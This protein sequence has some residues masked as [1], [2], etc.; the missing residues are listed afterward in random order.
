MPVLPDLLLQMWLR[1]DLRRKRKRKAPQDLMGI[2]PAE[3]NS[4]ATTGQSPNVSKKKLPGNPLLLIAPSGP[5]QSGSSH[6]GHA[7]RLKFWQVHLNSLGKTILTNMS[8]G[9]GVSVVL[10]LEQMIGALRTKVLEQKSHHPGRPIILVGWNVGA[11]VA[12]H[13]SLVESVNAVVCLGFPFTGLHGPRGDCEDPLLGSQTPT[14]FV[15]GQNTCDCS[16]DQLQDLREHMR[17]ETGMLVVGGADEQLRLSHRQKRE[18][19]LTQA[20]ADRCIIDEVYQFLGSILSMNASLP[21]LP[22]ADVAQ[23][24]L[25]R[26]RK[27][28]APQDLMGIIP[29]ENNSFA[30]TGQSPNVSKPPVLVSGTGRGSKRGGKAARLATSFGSSTATAEGTRTTTRKRQA[31]GGMGAGPRKRIALGLSHLGMHTTRSS[32]SL[33]SSST[34]TVSAISNAPELSGLLQG[35]RISRPSEGDSVVV[36]GTRSLVGTSFPLT[37]VLTFSKLVEGGDAGNSGTLSAPATLLASAIRSGDTSDKDKAQQQQFLVKT[38]GST[39]SPLA[40]PISMAQRLMAGGSSPLVHI[41]GTASSGSSQIHQLLTSI[42]CSSSPSAPL[43]PQAALL[44]NTTA[45]SS[46]P[47]A[48]VTSQGVIRERAVPEKAETS[49]HVPREKDICETSLKE[50][51]QD[52]VVLN[53][54]SSEDSDLPQTTCVTNTCAVIAHISQKSQAAVSETSQAVTHVMQSSQAN[55]TMAATVSSSPTGQL[56]AAKQNCLTNP[57]IPGQQSSVSKATIGKALPSLSHNTS[58]TT[59][60]S[61]NSP[62]TDMILSKSENTTSAQVSPI[63]KSG[64][65]QLAVTKS[66]INTAAVTTHSVLRVAG[67]VTQSGQAGAPTAT[68]SILGG[69]SAVLISP[70]IA[71]SLSSAPTA[72]LLSKSSSGSGALSTT[73]KPAMEVLG[74]VSSVLETAGKGQQTTQSSTA[75]SSLVTVPVSL[76]KSGVLSKTGVIMKSDVISALKVSRHGTPIPSQTSACPVSVGSSSAVTPPSLTTTATAASLSVGTGAG[77]GGH[78]SVNAVSYTASSKPVLPTPTSTRTRKIKTP[79]QYDL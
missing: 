24:D 40:I 63:V 16:I 38:G 49:E 22:P 14:L 57:A 71:K 37:K 78:K 45:P 47:A 27:R 74:K 32:T 31:R 15:I 48:S 30:T 52:S 26:K 4:F 69:R 50:A 70:A 44:I 7:K 41:T 34:A 55:L 51:G 23:V 17:A 64:F 33:P 62:A 42:A 79:K 11:L 25:R 1:L 28:K 21:D 61:L 72:I 53:R 19:G 56:S 36:G 76:S 29:A 12:C 43:Q 39:G 5:T 75:G 73:Y 54:Q 66:L 58:L 65:V 20:M 18:E 9:S 2:I 35:I 3:N 13:V 67:S 60:P 68:T 59:S 8:G 46:L 6:T 10:C 77:R